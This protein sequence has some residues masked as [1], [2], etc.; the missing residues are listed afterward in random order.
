MGSANS[1]EDDGRT[2]FDNA[3]YDMLIDNALPNKKK[4]RSRN[5]PAVIVWCII[6]IP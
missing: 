1:A 2:D 3:N 5:A 6:S 4:R